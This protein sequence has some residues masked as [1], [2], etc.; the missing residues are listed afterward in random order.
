MSELLP[1]FPL[2]NVVL[3]P[4]I[5]NYDAK[6]VRG[7]KDLAVRNLIAS[8]TGATPPEMLNPEVRSKPKG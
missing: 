5:G 4:H 7:I 6:T 8:L 2:P 3:L 1:L